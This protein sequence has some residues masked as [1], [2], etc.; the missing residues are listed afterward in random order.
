MK[1]SQRG[2][3]KTPI[4]KKSDH[5]FLSFFDFW[6][7]LIVKLFL[8]YYQLFFLSK[9]FL[10]TGVLPNPRW[11]KF[12]DFYKIWKKEKKRQKMAKK[13]SWKFVIFWILKKVDSQ[14][15]LTLLSTFFSIEEI[16]ENGVFEFCQKNRKFC[17]FKK[18]WR[19]FVIFKIL[20]KFDSQTF[21]TLLSKKKSIEEI[22]ENGVFLVKLEKKVSFS[23]IITIEKKVDSKSEKVWL[24]NIFKIQKM[25]KNEV[26]KMAKNGKKSDHEN[27]SFFDFWKNLIVK[28]FLLYYQIFFL[29]KRFLKMGVGPNPRWLIFW[30]YY[31]YYQ[32]KN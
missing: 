1:N 11:L 27:L 12:W 24:S 16:F 22:F 29:S 5:D 15:F 2:F 32:L 26:Q 7:N 18:W 14:T 10:K 19:F 8:L 4:F 20:K 17:N 28:L 3:D 21:F 25:T 30:F 31:C 13:W 6:K 9:R 23:K